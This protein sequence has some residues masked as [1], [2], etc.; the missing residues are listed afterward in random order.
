MPVSVADLVVA[1]GPG[2][3]SYLIA[4]EQRTSSRDLPA[5]LEAVLAGEVDRPVYA[6]ALGEGDAWFV[7][8]VDAEDGEKAVA[9]TSLSPILVMM[10]VVDVHRSTRSGR[11]R[12]GRP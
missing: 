11:I 10:Y 8:A 2:A 12:C 1:L 9:S 7:C 6:A 4:C 5:G 3:T